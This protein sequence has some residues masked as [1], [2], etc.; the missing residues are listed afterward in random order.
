MSENVSI[1]VQSTPL[2][3]AMLAATLFPYCG[4]SIEREARAVDIA[5][6]LLWHARARIMEQEAEEEHRRELA[7][8]LK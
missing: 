5:C 2:E 1:W 4:N 8:V 6:R 7:K 3:L